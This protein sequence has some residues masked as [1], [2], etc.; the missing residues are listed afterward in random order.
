MSP[1]A[2][3]P[4][5]ADWEDAKA[6]YS[7]ALGLGIKDC[8]YKSAAK[9]GQLYL[10]AGGPEI[11]E[12]YFSESCRLSREL[13]ERSPE[14]YEALFYLGLAE[15]GLGKAEDAERHYL[16]ALGMCSA[17]GVKSEVISDIDDFECSDSRQAGIERVRA[18]ICGD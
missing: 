14:I 2:S 10:R 18:L 1:G 13:L 6:A 5:T 7:S 17:P 3:R 9:L 16:E 15:L 12:E 4:T 11:A 8:S